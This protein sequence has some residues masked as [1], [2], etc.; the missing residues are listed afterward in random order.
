M[1]DHQNSAFARSRTATGQP[2]KMQLIAQTNTP[3][4]KPASIAFAIHRAR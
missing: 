3:T 1:Q 4:A 2:A